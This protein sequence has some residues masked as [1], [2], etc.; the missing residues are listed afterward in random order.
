M[1]N[2]YNF[3]DSLFVAWEIAADVT[4]YTLNIKECH[5]LSLFLISHT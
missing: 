4:T 3:D 5:S 1:K 2:I